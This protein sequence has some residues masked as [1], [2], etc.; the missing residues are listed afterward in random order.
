MIDQ[1]R[2][3]KTFMELCAIDSEPTGERLMA[4]RLI[5]KLTG[6]GFKVV[7]DDSGSRIG[8]NAGNLYARLE[9][10]TAGEA[11]LFSCHMDRVA[12]GVGV[13]PSIEGDYFVSDGTTVLGA[14]DASGLAAILEAVTALQQAGRAHPAIELVLTVAEE[15]SLLGSRQFDTS[16]VSSRTGFVLD[17]SGDVGEI[18]L[19]APEHLKFSAVFQGVAAH[20]G[21]NPEHGISAIQIAAAAISRMELLR[22]DSDTTANLGSITAVGPTNIVQN[23]CELKGEVRSLVPEKARSHMETLADAMKG[24]A[25]EYGGSV[26]IETAVSYRAYRLPEDSAPVLRAARAAAEIGV[27]VRF[28]S[29]GGGSDANHFN[30]RG[31]PTVVLSCGYE[32]VHTTEE[33]LPLKQLLLLTRWVV[34]IIEDGVAE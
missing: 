8:G 11:L 24:A 27:P 6:L 16:P 17:A 31:L 15:L 13:K 28:K 3:F 19:Q 14:D 22:I 4:D 30:A 2:L 9:G 29:T 7:E 12:P 20:A 33:R 32:K 21:F 1:N 18:V 34:A 25:A 23:R 26:T 5:E 10:T